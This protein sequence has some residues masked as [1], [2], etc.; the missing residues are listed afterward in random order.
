MQHACNTHAGRKRA[1]ILSRDENSTREAARCRSAR[2]LAEVRGRG[3]PYHPNTAVAARSWTACR[4]I[5][6][7][8]ALLDA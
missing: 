6:G 7:E 2:S 8:R 3:G 1:S 5:M 4:L